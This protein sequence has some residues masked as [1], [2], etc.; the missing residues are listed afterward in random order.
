[1]QEEINDYSFSPP[2]RRFS[3]TDFFLPDFNETEEFLGNILFLVDTSGSVDDK[4]MTQA[5]SEI[6]GAIDQF[7]GKLSGL[8]GFFDSEVYDPVPFSCVDDV[9]KI[10]PRGGGGTSF[11][12]IFSYVQQKMQEPPLS[13]VILT[14]GYAPFPEES[15]A[16]GI[17]VLWVI[18]NKWEQIKP[19]F[20]KVVYL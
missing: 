1:M 4:S 16:R 12:A 17:P 13:I 15:A 20:G 3:D 8:L 5:Y 10:R 18:Q 7:G 2:D 11:K 14:D 19:P 6:C 9:K